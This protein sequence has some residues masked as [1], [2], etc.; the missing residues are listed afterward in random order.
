MFCHS[1]GGELPKTAKFC[2]HCGTEVLIKQESHYMKK[3]STLSFIIN[4]NRNK[5]YQ[6]EKTGLGQAPLFKKIADIKQSGK[7]ILAISLIVLV[8]VIAISGNSSN[9]RCG[10][11]SSSGS[12]SSGSGSLF[13][14]R[15][16]PKKILDCLTC[17]G[18]GDCNTCGGYGRESFYAGAGDSVDAVCSTCHGSGN[19]RTCGGSGKR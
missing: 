17:D 13:F 3:D 15:E 1:C 16:E 8:T 11:G 4:K 14:D 5:T 19:C 12:S 2:P 9:S 7:K 10:G 6:R 18:D